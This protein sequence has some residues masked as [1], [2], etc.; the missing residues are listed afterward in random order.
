[1]QRPKRARVVLNHPI[2]NILMG[3]T[4]IATPVWGS[5]WER[6]HNTSVEWNLEFRDLQARERAGM[7]AY[8]CGMHR[9]EH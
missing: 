1:M 7:V 6:Y 5:G 4:R 9:A 3:A 2:R 8:T